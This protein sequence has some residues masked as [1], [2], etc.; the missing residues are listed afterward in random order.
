MAAGLPLLAPRAGGVL[1]YA[2]EGNSW[3]REPTGPA[4]AEGVLEILR[5]E[6]GRK[7]KLSQ[8]RW[9]AQQFGWENVSQ[10]FFASYDRMVDQFPTTRFAVAASSLATREPARRAGG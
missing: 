1:S 3:L 10:Q 4:F 7:E 8:A 6:T 5:D 9:T 2:H